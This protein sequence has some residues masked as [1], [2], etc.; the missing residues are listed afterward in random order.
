MQR[1]KL[2]ERQKRI[3]W[4]ILGI[5]A[6]LI[7]LFPLYWMLVTSVR[8]AGESYVSVSMLPSKIDLSNYVM[9]KRGNVSVITYFKN[10]VLISMGAMLFT[11]ILGIP[12]AYGI[13]RYKSRAS[14]LMLFI[15][16]MAQMLPSSLILTPL[17]INYNKLGLINTRIAV[18]LSDVT[19]TIPFSVIILRTYFKNIPKELEEAAI[20][21][22]CGN[23]KTFTHIMI[24]MCYPGIVTAMVMSLFMAWGDMIF[25]L[26][27][28][29]DEK[30]R[31]LPLILYKAMGELGVQWELLMAYSTIVVLPILVVF[32]F[33]QKYIVSGLTAGSVKG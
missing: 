15:F 19:L 7:F 11:V 10:S 6:A 2:N 31:T 30:K 33:S 18:M 27:F 5:A 13:G 16:L 8:P 32:V 23:F 28:V 4:G 22:G 25:S 14:S 9:Q 12:A 20:I 26:T 24:P 17:F 29:M 1:I 3:F 21:D